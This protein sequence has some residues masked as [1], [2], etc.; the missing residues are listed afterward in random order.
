M[1]NNDHILKNTLTNYALVILRIVQGVLVTRWL[2][3]SLGKEYYGF[4]SLLWMILIYALLLD[5]GFSKAAQKYTATGLFQHDPER[6]N[7]Y[8]SAVFSLL[9]LMT[10][11]ISAGTF[12]A[13]H[14]LAALTRIESPEQ[15]AYCQRT[16]K[17]FGVGSALVFPTGI[18]PEILVGLRK[19]YLRNYVLIGARI[20]ETMGIIGILAMG[21]SLLA[22]A[23]FSI[24]LNLGSNMLNYALCRREI[25]SLRLRLRWDPLTLKELSDFSAYIYLISISRLV[26]LKTD[27]LLL[28]IFSGLN[29]VAVYQLGGRLPEL[30]SNLATQYQENLAPISAALHAK[31]QQKNLREVIFFA[32]RFSS[33]MAVGGISLALIIC[34]D[35]IALLFKVQDPEVIQ[36]CRWLLINASFIIA[37]RSVTDRFLMMSGRHRL[38]TGISMSEAL[39]NLLLSL[40]LIRRYGVLGVIIGTLIP[41][42]VIAIALLLPYIMIFV[43]RSAL[44]FIDKV[45]LRPA[46]AALLMALAVIGIKQLLLT[47]SWPQ[48]LQLLVIILAAGIVYCAVFVLANPEDWQAAQQFLRQKTKKILPTNARAEQ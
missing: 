39:A 5:F 47:S 28:S 26:L 1:K 36:A 8:L 34:Q 44:S 10:L 42:A 24:S 30:S 13:S 15:L 23:I 33:F 32:M 16:L 43:R 46:L 14:F 17:V 35:L 21:G 9:A 6:Y 48:L 3:N 38:L 20:T 18:F 27:H 37:V 2:F 12:V 29:A 40:L 4:W 45:Y 7:R 41:N 22:L 19:I 31:N 25:P 11:I